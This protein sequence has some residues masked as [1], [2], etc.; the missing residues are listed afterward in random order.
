MEKSIKAELRKKFVQK[1]NALTAVERTRD[2]ALIRHRIFSHPHWPDVHTILMYVSFRSE[3][4]T[5]KL[6]QE[7]LAQSK[8]VVVPVVDP[9]RKEL[10]LSELNALGDLAPGAFHGILEPASFLRKSVIPMEIEWVL[11]PGLAF[12]RQGGRLG[13]GGGYFDKLLEN[14]PEARRIGLAYSSQISAKPLPMQA[15]DVRMHEIITE[16]EVIKIS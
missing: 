6:I 4:E 11:V 9:K 14:M 8:R 2:S 10:D 7:T 5:G 1:R 12:D 3:V 15:H 13:L 16:K